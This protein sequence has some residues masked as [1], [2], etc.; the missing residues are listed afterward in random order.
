[1]VK[2]FAEKF[3]LTILSCVDICGEVRLP[4][5]EL[6]NAVVLSMVVVDIDVYG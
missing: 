2:T 3:V 5:I 1:M 4:I 6:L